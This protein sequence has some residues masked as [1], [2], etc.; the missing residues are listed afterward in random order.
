VCELT[1]SASIFGVIIIEGA[2]YPP[3]PLGPFGLLSEITDKLLISVISAKG[4]YA[5]AAPSMNEQSSLMVV[6]LQM[7]M[8]PL[9]WIKKQLLGTDELWYVYERVKEQS[10]L[11][12]VQ[13]QMRMVP[14]VWMKKQLLGTDE[15][16]YVY[17]RVKEQSSLM[18]VQLQMRM[19]PLVWIK[20]QLLGTD[21]L[22]YVYERV[23]EQ[24]SLMVVQ[25]QMRMV[26]LVW[27]KKQLLGTD[28]LWPMCESEVAVLPFVWVCASEEVLANHWLRL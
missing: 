1:P 25:L 13:L 7:R 21:E 28:E 10:S 24:S 18:V 11:M 16:W 2:G 9:V 3:L 19:F 4:S 26:P 12:V 17:E 5:K 8:V 27:I 15:L 22:W 14:L 20:K 23:K 6:Q